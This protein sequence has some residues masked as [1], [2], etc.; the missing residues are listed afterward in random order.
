[1]EIPL[2]NLIYSVKPVDSRAG[3]ADVEIKLMTAEFDEEKFKFYFVRYPG[4]YNSI[5]GTVYFEDRPKFYYRWMTLSELEASI[6]NDD[7]FREFEQYIR[8]I[9]YAE[10]R[11]SKQF[12]LLKAIA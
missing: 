3:I 9:R 1:M 5:E 6:T 4:Q 8:L 11:I 7:D 10:Y 2:T 12:G